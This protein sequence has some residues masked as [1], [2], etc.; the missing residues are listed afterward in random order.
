MLNPAKGAELLSFWHFNEGSVTTVSLRGVNA[1]L[2]L[3]TML[4]E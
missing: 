3:Q 1:R 2:Y 4:E